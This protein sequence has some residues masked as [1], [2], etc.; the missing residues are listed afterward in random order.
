MGFGLALSGGGLLG[1][2]HLGVLVGL[3]ELGLVP[4]ILTGTSAGGLAAG[5]VS[6]QVSLEEFVNFGAA[7]SARPVHYFAPQVV[8][9]ALDL[10]PDDPFLPATGIFNPRRFVDGLLNLAAGAATTE[11]WRCPTAVT[12]VDLA[13]MKAVAFVK[14][15]LSGASSPWT[16]V[17]GAPLSVALA[18]TMAMPGVFAAVPWEGK[19]LVDGGVADTLPV[20]WAFKLGAER[21]VAVEVSA[22]GKL[23]ARP[24]IETVLSR[25]MAFATATLSALRMPAN[26]PIFRLTPDTSNVP[27]FGFR[28]Y[29]RLVDAGRQAV[30]A[31]RSE[32]VDFV[33]GTTTA[34]RKIG[35]R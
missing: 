7:V 32:L 28:D 17:R 29:A 9:I 1:A 26:R 11:S 21:V 19:M 4:S 3:Q 14:G 23:P 22:S 24:G 31:A 12:S 15:A 27:F 33:Q 16:I 34:S 20:D 8:N 13:Q 25:S 30:S 10:L 18:A 5:I 35:D 2:A 6:L